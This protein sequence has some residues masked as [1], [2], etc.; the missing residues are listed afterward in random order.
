MLNGWPYSV[1]L[2]KPDS[3]APWI[4][5]RP[6]I[7]YRNETK[8]YE[9]D[10]SNDTQVIDLHFFRMLGHT[11][12]KHSDG[13]A[14]LSGSK[15]DFEAALRFAKYGGSTP[16]KINDLHLFGSKGVMSCHLGASSLISS[17][18]KKHR[19]LLVENVPELTEQLRNLS[20]ANNKKPGAWAEAYVAGE[21]LEATGSRID[22][23][24]LDEMSAV[25][26]GYQGSARPEPRL[27]L[28]HYKQARNLL[29]KPVSSARKAAAA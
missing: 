5:P 12:C 27:M 9:S 29:G 28:R 4:R 21:L 6:R 19:E 8:G 20:T 25:L 16:K 15:F 17:K 26:F 18:L 23:A 11:V 1:S 13:L 14:A 3:I 7:T 22:S 2:F 24:G 10:F